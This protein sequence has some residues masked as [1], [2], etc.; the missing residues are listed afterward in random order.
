MVMASKFPA[1]P[2][3]VRAPELNERRVRIGIR[4]Q[5]D[6][7]MEHRE[8]VIGLLTEPNPTDPGR[9]VAHVGSFDSRIALL[10][11]AARTRKLESVIPSA[12]RAAAG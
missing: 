7:L 11:A 9:L 8:L 4:Q 3:P 6:R 10:V 2:V 12:T 5:V 1:K